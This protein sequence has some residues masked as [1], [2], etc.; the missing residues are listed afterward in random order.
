M[1]NPNYIKYF[2][3]P[4]LGR[5][6]NDANNKFRESVFT[7]MPTFNKEFYNDP[8]YGDDWLNFVFNF[9]NILKKICPTYH[10]YQV[11]HKAGRNY[12]YDYVFTFIDNLNNKICDEKIEFKYNASCISD[13]P[14]FVSPMKPSNYLSQSFEE[15]FYDNYFK[16]LLQEF[17]FDIPD[18]NE[19]IKN[20]GKPDPV[21][22]KPAQDLY[23]EGAKGSS[24]YTNQQ[25]AIDFHKK[26][27]AVSKI[28]IKN[29]INQT[30]LNIEKL[31][32]YL[33]ESQNNKIYLLY[34]N[35]KFN[36]Q[37]INNDDYIIESYTKVPNKHM[38]NAVT[39]S[40]KKMK[41]LLRWKNGNGIA[42]PAFQIS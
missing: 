33:I 9:H 20:V 22:I 36:I 37:K 35:G 1:I 19:Y 5:S 27:K 12:N 40:G 39:K 29:F 38:Y 34:K 17:E 8:E 10:S 21:C 7:N 13:A 3:T 31:T 11:Q 24:R 16:D 32:Q 41:I 25:R 28:A 4:I 2:K 42:F 6:N 23:Y 26:C 30:E 18:K 14:Q 15:Y